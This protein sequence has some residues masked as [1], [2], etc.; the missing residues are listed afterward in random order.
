MLSKGFVRGV[1]MYFSLVSML[2]ACGGGR[3]EYFYS[4][5]ADADKAGEIMRG[6]LPDDLV[7]KSSRDIRLVE[8][9]SPDYEWCVFDFLR[10]VT[11]KT[12]E[13]ISRVSINYRPRSQTLPVLGSN[14]GRRCFR[15]TSSEKTS[16][17]PD[18][19]RT[20]QRHG[21][22]VLGLSFPI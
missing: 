12:S 1:V 13:R 4:T 5:L 9:L 21:K 8:E 7:P 16:T 6:W 17:T 11:R 15:G 3:N 14:G 10:P 2:A 20:T 18:S 19:S 22:P